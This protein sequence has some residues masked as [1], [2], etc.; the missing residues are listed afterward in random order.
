MFPA[1]LRDILLA[2]WFNTVAGK[3]TYRGFTVKKTFCSLL[4]ASAPVV[5]AMAAP[6]AT[7]SPTAAQ[8]ATSISAQGSSEHPRAHHRKGH[9]GR[10]LAK[11][12]T[13]RHPR[14]NA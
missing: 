4:L 11:R 14:N 6:V 2:V 13:H 1:F 5:F 12:R 9:R 7:A 10:A 8:P 3:F